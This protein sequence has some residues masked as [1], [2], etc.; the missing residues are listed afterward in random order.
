MVFKDKTLFET[1][2]PQQIVYGRRKKIIKPKIQN[3]RN[4]FILKKKK[5]KLK[6]E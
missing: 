5:R 4:Y 6:I 3:I 2:K 1:N